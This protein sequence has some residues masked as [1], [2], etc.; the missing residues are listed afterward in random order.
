MPDSPPEMRRILFVCAGNTC[1]SPMAAAIAQELLG[2]TV[3][4]ESAGISAVDGAS[5]ASDAIQT[6][7]ERGLDISAH[8]SRSLSTL[9]LRDF[10]LVVALTRTIAQDIRR[11]GVE[12]SRVAVLNV[13]DPYNKEL[14]V[15]RAT[16]AAIERGL[17]KLF[18]AN[19]EQP[20]RQ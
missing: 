1:R 4:V 16:A 17:Q 19:R 9:N 20:K 14:D 18:D 2:A 15:Y 12:P 3:Q 5:A 13:P 8:R 11:G 6:M 10:D 7:R